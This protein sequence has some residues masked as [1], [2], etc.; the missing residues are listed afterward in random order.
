M[1]ISANGGGNASIFSE[2]LK[3]TQGDSEVM[4][5]KQAFEGELLNA[6]KF[7]GL[8]KA[9]LTEL[10]SIVADLRTQ[11][12]RPVRVFPL[13]IPASDGI[14]IRTVLDLGGLQT[15][16]TALPKIQRLR[17]IEVFPLGIPRPDQFMTKVEFG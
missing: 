5:P 9:N 10:V 17:S 15:L 6:L 1:T 16:I 7:G 4:E 8:E 12:I 2:C 3:G 13:G 14:G 11:G